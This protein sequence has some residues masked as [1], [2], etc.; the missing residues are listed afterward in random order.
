VAVLDITQ[1]PF[2]AVLMLRSIL[3]LFPFEGSV[4]DVT[5]AMLAPIL[6]L[7]SQ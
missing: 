6:W 5:A 3:M 1:K 7:R 4:F 2:E